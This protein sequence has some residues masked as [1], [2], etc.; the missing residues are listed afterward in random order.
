VTLSEEVG[1]RANLA[2]CLDGLATVAGAQGEVERSARLSGAAEGLH[3]AV[4]VPAY[5]YY[6]PHR[7]LYERTVTAVRSR[8]GETAFERARSEGRAMSFELAV[9]YALEGKTNTKPGY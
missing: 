7:S 5:I 8:L 9:A 1:D 3:Q 2:H 6:E 4:G